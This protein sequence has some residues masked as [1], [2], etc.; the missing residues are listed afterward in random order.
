VGRQVRRLVGLNFH[1]KEPETLGT[2]P[3]IYWVVD[4]SSL[5]F[6]MRSRFANS[7]QSYPST[8]LGAAV[9]LSQLMAG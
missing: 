8:Y 1:I 9:P 6:I 3:Y 5:P 2:L 4:S 7:V